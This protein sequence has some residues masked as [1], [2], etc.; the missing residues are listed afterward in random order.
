M[1]TL[2]EAR[3]TGN[4][5]Q[6][7]KQHRRDPK[8]SADAFNRTLEAMAGKSKAVPATSKKRNPDD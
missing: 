7:V 2:K 3:E 6:F 4:L 1:T 5:T 8:G